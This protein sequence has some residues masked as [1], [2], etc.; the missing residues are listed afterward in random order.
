MII[1]S[2]LVRVWIFIYK[3]T[4]NNPEQSNNYQSQSIEHYETES[5]I[6]E[7]FGNIIDHVHERKEVHKNFTNPYHNRTATDH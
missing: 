6:Q 5:I 3:M 4:M 1:I 2:I 7:L